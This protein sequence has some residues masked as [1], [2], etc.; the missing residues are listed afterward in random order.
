MTP[1]AKGTT[2]LQRVQPLYKG[3]NLSI[4]GTASLQRYNLSIKGTTSLQRVQPLYKGT[5]SL[6]RV[7]PLYKGQP[8]YKGCNNL[9]IEGTASLQ[10]VLFEVMGYCLSSEGCVVLPLFRGYCLR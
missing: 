7:Q 4:K 10:W 3:Y 8:P 5:T 9:S 2:S 1:S 6:Q